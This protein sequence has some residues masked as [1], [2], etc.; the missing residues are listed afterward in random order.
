MSR[1]SPYFAGA[2][3]WGVQVNGRYAWEGA[4]AFGAITRLNFDRSREVA[5]ATRAQQGGWVLGYLHELDDQQE[6]VG[7]MMV[8]QPVFRQLGQLS[9]NTYEVHLG[10]RIHLSRLAIE[11]TLIENLF[12]YYNSPDWGMNLGVR[13][14]IF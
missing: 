7:Q 8:Y 2:S 6:L 14:L 3:D 4:A 11:L 9:R 13:S 5:V 10:Y 12:Y 1:A